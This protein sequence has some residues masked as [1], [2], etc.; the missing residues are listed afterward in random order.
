MF[1]IQD[2]PFIG[3][4]AL[5]YDDIIILV[6]GDGLDPVDDLGKEVVVDIADDHPDGF[7]AASFKALGDG[8]G[9]VIMFAGVVQDD[10]FRFPAD[11][12]ASAQ[13]LRHTRNR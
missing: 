3:F 9:L 2:L 1:H 8:I 6:V 13:G 11:L 5:G 7:A 4:L 10:L 12:M